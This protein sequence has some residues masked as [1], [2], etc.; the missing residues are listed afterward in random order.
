MSIVIDE[1]DEIDD[2]HDGDNAIIVG[3]KLEN[4]EYDDIELI[5][6][7][8][9]VEDLDETDEMLIAEDMIYE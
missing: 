4:E 5:D 2:I 6:E 8:D 9:D 7:I 1:H 3:Q